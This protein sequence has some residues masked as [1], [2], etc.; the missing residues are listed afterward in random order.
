MPAQCRC[1][2]ADHGRTGALVHRQVQHRRRLPRHRDGRLAA[3]RRPRLRLAARRA[4]LDQPGARMHRI[5]RWR[6]ATP[7]RSCLK[8]R[9][10]R[11][12]AAQPDCSNCSARRSRRVRAL[13]AEMHGSPRLADR[14]HPARLLVP[15]RRSTSTRQVVQRYSDPRRERQLPPDAFRPWRLQT[16]PSG[17]P[18]P[19]A[20]LP[21]MARLCLRVRARTPG[22]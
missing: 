4:L 3:R 10:S 22:D 13:I 5:S 8:A 7:A 6:A 11:K 18:P 1:V 14:L 16:S 20:G 19:A 12:A 2:T 17:N 21:A 9:R 15:N